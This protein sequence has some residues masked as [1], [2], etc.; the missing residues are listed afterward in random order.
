MNTALITLS[1]AGARLADLL[2]SRLGSCDTYLH[3]SLPCAPGTT[4]FASIR[5][6][7]ARIFRRYAG[8]L[9]IA[10]CG[11]VM[12]A[13]AP[14][15]QDKHSD[16]AVVAVDA[17]GRYAVSLLGGHEAGANDLAL[18]AANAI[19]A[20]PVISTTTEALKPLIVGVGCRRGIEAKR[21]AAAVREA[22]ADAGAAPEQVRFIATADVK[23]GEEGL[24][25]AAA[26]LGLPLRIVASAEIRGCLREFTP[27]ALATEK[28]NLP[29]VAEPAALLAGRRTR[30]RLPRRT[31]N[32]ITV[33]IAEEGFPWS[34]S[35]PAATWTARGGR[36]RR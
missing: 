2:A 21:V 30:L 5:D 17:G 6:L 35:D 15:V 18:R 31:Y 33:A 23:A 26:E 20:E 4:P 34:E 9:Y 29:A 10:P 22:L 8:L 1:A 7:T 27:S 32:G 13:V 36:N 19:G 14:H 11:V 28:I 16:P 3:R 25:T 24:I 12:R